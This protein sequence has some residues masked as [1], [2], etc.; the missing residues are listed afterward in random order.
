MIS[1]LTSRP[2]A[3]SEYSLAPVPCGWPT[4]VRRHM[5]VKRKKSPR[6]RYLL[7]RGYLSWSSFSLWQRDRPSF[8]MKYYDGEAR[9]VETDYTR[10]G[11]EVAEALESRRY[12][13]ALGRNVYG[14]FGASPL[15]DRVVAGHSVSEQ[16]LGAEIDGVIV[17]GFADL[18]DP[19][20]CSIREVKTGLAT[21]PWTPSR[22]ARH[23]QLVWYSL[24][25]EDMWGRVHPNVTLAW[26]PTER[27]ETVVTFGSRS[28]SDAS[29]AIRLTGR[30]HVFRRA[31]TDGERASMRRRIVQAAEEITDDYRKWLAARGAELSTAP[32]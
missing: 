8:R 13:Y 23:D 20:T 12:D 3:T 18:M 24:M 19:L 32:V 7:P 11:K 1:R 29:G 28:F 15:L 30:L 9:D 25:A 22:V 17:K 5:G 31:I 6:A 10:F 16:P 27:E 4:V 26:L 14:R 2:T 21:S